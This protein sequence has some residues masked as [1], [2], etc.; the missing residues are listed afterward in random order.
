[1][2]SYTC[3]NWDVV[4]LVSKSFDGELISRAISKLGFSVIRGSSS[5]GGTEA[6]I[7]I[8]NELEKFSRVA[9][10]PDGP[11]GPAYQVSK[12]IV[13]LAQKSQ[14]KIFSGVIDA[15][16]AIRLSSWDRFMIPLPFAK[17]LVSFGEPILIP[18]D[19]EINNGIVLLQNAMNSLTV[20]NKNT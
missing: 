17:V 4:V 10:T 18:S 19:M 13:M 1:M 11:R 6:F 2:W 3:R 7:S 12:G 15:S 9:I 8:L 20:N 14:A 5:K 16:P